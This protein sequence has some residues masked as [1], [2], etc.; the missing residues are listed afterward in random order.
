MK[1]NKAVFLDRDGVITR[2]APE[3]DFVKTAEELVYLPKV[4]QMIG[5]LKEKGYLVIVVSNQS[6]INRGIIKRENFEMLRLC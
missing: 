3:K 2:K 6:G 1:M 4:K 5:A